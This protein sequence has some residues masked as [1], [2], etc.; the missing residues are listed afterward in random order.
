MANKDEAANKRDLKEYREQ[1]ALLAKTINLKVTNKSVNDKAIGDDIV[2][3]YTIT[4][5]GNTPVSAFKGEPV[6][7]DVFNDTLSIYQVKNSAAIEPGQSVKSGRFGPDNEIVNIREAGGLE[8]KIKFTDFEK[9]KFDWHPVE[10]IF[11]DGKRI[12]VLDN[13]EKPDF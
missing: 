10:I 4:N 7:K 11:K 2:F 12:N 13:P 5:N 3:D 8:S 1:A 6:V 9:L